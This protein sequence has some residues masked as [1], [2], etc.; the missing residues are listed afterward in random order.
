MMFA[1]T[2]AEIRLNP[3]SRSISLPRKPFVCTAD[4]QHGIVSRMLFTPNMDPAFEP[5]FRVR[6]AELIEQRVPARHFSASHGFRAGAG[7]ACRPRRTG[8]RIG[9]PRSFQ[10]AAGPTPTRCEAHR[11][12]APR[13]SDLHGAGGGHQA[14]ADAS[15][16][17]GRQPVCTSGVP[18]FSTQRTA[19]Q[20]MA[21]DTEL[22]P[23]HRADGR[24]CEAPAG[25]G[26]L[27]P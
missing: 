3:M 10:V 9:L 24:G 22:A 26:P 19:R 23:R 4:A 27:E 16:H 8:L 7:H 25:P 14:H 13:L 2:S 11:H 12:G 20:R 15:H 5:D 1:G 17:P 18:A 6:L 21:A